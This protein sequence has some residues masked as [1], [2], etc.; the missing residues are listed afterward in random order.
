MTKSESLNPGLSNRPEKLVRFIT[1]RVEYNRFNWVCIRRTG[2]RP[3]Q[4]PCTPARSRLGG[5]SFFVG[6]RPLFPPPSRWHRGWL[7]G[8]ISTVLWSDWPISGRIT[9]GLYQSAMLVN[10]LSSIARPRVSPTTICFSE[11]EERDASRSRLESPRMTTP[12]YGCFCVMSSTHITVWSVM[13]R[14]LDFGGL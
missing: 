11:Y 1:V 2:N 7:F 9:E 6:G 8:S 10:I 14:P 12:A 13:A 3:S 4:F 5:G